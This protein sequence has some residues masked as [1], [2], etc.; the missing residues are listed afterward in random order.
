MRKRAGFALTLF[1]G[2]AMAAGPCLAQ[3]ETMGSLWTDTP[4]R[5]DGLTQEWQDATFHTDAKSKAEYAFKNDGENLY[6]LFVF[7]DRESLSTLEANGMTVYYNLDGRKRKRDGLHFVRRQLTPQQLI[8]LMEERGE[9]MPEER[10]AQI[11]SQPGYILHDGEQVNPPRKAGPPVR[12]SRVEFPTFRGQQQEKV[13]F[14]EYRI[15]LEREAR[16]GGL[17]AQPGQ[18]VTLG[19]EWGGMTKEMIAKRM[20]QSAEAGTRAGEGG[21]S[22]GSQIE[23]MEDSRADRG[24][25]GGVDLKRPVTAKKHSF[26]IDVKLA[27]ESS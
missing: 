13:F 8:A 25:S 20:T 9:F 5:I 2:A 15:P 21:T 23:S 10:K 11:L 17:G 12:S 4:V 18:T 24:R 26:W 27:G 3:D 19:F 6:I 22:L 14:Y 16:I 1:I 7:R